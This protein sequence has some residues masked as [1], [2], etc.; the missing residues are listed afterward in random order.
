MKDFLAG[1]LFA[2]ILCSVGYGILLI[3]HRRE[4]RQVEHEAF[5]ECYQAKRTLLQYS[6]E[7]NRLYAEIAR[8]KR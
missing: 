4:L 7:R 5:Q 2:L 1:F 6:K 8:L 3:D